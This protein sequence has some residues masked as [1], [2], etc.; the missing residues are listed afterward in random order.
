MLAIIIAAGII[1]AAGIAIGLSSFSRPIQQSEET[2]TPT[3][4]PTDNEVEPIE[5][6]SGS[7]AVNA[8]E[9]EIAYNAFLQAGWPE[10]SAAVFSSVKTEYSQSNSTFAQFSQTLPSGIIQDVRIV[11]T[12]GQKYVPAEAEKIY[13]PFGSIAY[14]TDA[15]FYS[16]EES[17]A[18]KISYFLPYDSLDH[19]LVEQMGWSDPY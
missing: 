19:E 16:S 4:Q 8:T 17:N 13:T 1:A 10:Q 3:T 15:E 11:V 18:S 2:P 14:V 6:G 12:L 9:K 5:E 7:T